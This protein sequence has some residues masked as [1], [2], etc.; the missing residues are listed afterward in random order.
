[1]EQLEGVDNS[2]KKLKADF[3]EAS[4]KIISLEEELY[5]SKTVQVELLEQLKQLEDKFE[6]AVNRLEETEKQL[7]ESEKR[8]LSIDDLESELEYLQKQNHKLRYSVYIP[9]KADNTDQVLSEFINNRPE[10]E[11]LKIMFL[12]ESEGVYQFGQKRI[13][14]KVEKGQQI[15][16]RVGGGFMHID[17]F[18]N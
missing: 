15:M 3:Q 12:R 5:G 7:E 13:Y 9:K 14:V 1:M 10:N 17:D 8:M 18:I 6:D 2:R 4:D 11:A 16:V